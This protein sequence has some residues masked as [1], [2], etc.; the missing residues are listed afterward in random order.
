M[1]ARASGAYTCGMRQT[2]HAIAFGLAFAAPVSAGTCPAVP[3]RSGALTRLI[4]AVREAPDEASARLISNDMWA[5]WT[6]APD[7]HAQELLDEGMMRRAAFDFAGAVAAFDALVVYCPDFA[8]GY[9]Q[10][11]FVNFIRHDYS[12]AV[13]DLDRAVELSPRHLGALTGQA[14]TLAALGR[15]GEAALA[16]RKA[17]KLNPWLAERHLLPA[18]EA[19]EDDI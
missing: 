19:T 5:V 13:P 4:E 18:L 14:L 16:L 8:E 2:V 11:A 7:A 12:A 17:L 9:N 15:D 6:T 1:I 10:R 3:D